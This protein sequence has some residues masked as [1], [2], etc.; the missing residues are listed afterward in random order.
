MT[1][2]FEL[3]KLVSNSDLSIVRLSLDIIRMDLLAGG[4]KRIVGSTFFLLTSL[5]SLVD[6]VWILV[7][8]SL[9]FCVVISGT[10]GRLLLGLE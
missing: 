10:V 2:R 9:V 1:G 5:D 7:K 3:L 6:L 8:S 4:L